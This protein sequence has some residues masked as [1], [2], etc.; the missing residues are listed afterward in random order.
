MIIYSYINILKCSHPVLRRGH[1]SHNLLTWPI[2]ISAPGS[3][4]Q[5]KKDNGAD[6]CIENGWRDALFMAPGILRLIM[7]IVNIITSIAP[8][9]SW[10]YDAIENAY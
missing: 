5:S 3:I 6:D 2:R 1:V 4:S 9:G 7:M 10:V 8:H